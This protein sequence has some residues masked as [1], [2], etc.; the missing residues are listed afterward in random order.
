RGDT[1]PEPAS[2]Q[3][4]RISPLN[5]PRADIVDDARRREQEQIPGVPVGVKYDVLAQV[6]ELPLG[7]GSGNPHGDEHHRKELRE[8]PRAEDHWVS[9]LLAMR[10]RFHTSS[11]ISEYPS[12]LMCPTPGSVL[13]KPRTSRDDCTAASSVDF[14]DRHAT[15]SASHADR[16]AASSA[17][18]TM[19]PSIRVS[20]M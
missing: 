18:S 19:V 3:P 15:S 20:G 8:R 9:Y 2:L 12:A 10:A 1:R 14:S 6:D 5:L 4:A 11:A 17:R 7:P 16:N 13:G